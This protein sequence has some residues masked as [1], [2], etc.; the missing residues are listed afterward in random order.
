MRALAPRGASAHT[1]VAARLARAPFESPAT[2]PQ[3]AI[4][5]A[6]TRAWPLAQHNPDC[7]LHGDYW[8]GN[9]IWSD[10]ALCGVIDWADALV[11]DPLADVAIARLDLL[12]MLDAETM[13]AFTDAYFVAACY[14]A[15]QL[16]YWDL[17][18]TLRPG[19]NLA[20]WAEA[21]PT[22]GRPDITE[23]GMANAREQLAVWALEALA[24]NER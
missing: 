17:F 13:Q 9:L 14:D 16:P 4:R 1:V 3:A 20:S 10:G 6:L 7:L 22:L 23:Q 11:G 2:Y 15:A 21:W 12:W 8:A 5:S 18:A 19:A 24:R